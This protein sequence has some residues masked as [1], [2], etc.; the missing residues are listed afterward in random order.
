VRADGDED[1]AG[2]DDGDGGRSVPR[3]AA[4]EDLGDA[5]DGAAGDLT[6]SGDAMRWSPE[7][8]AAPPSRPSSFPGLDVAAGL[9]SALGLDPAQVR[10]LVSGAVTRMAT[11]AGEAVAEL[12]QRASDAFPPGDER[13]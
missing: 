11:I 10:R 2:R 3:R 8:A 6:V 5:L 4:S 13:R 7:Q 12:R 9:G 1:G